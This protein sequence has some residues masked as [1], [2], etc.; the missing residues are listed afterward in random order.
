MALGKEYLS[1]NSDRKNNGT[2]PLALVRGGEGVGWGKPGV[3]AAIL[4]LLG[5]HFEVICDRE[6]RQEWHQVNL[7]RPPLPVHLWL[8]QV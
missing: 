7:P 3:Q 2:E 6:S 4:F 8:T 1:I 5:K